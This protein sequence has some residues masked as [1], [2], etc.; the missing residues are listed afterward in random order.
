MAV[1]VAAPAAT[2]DVARLENL[3]LQRIA[4]FKR[5]RYW[6]VVD[7]LPKNS[8]GKVLKRELRRQFANARDGA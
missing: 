2:L 4:R 3:C 7:A 6:R 1:L 5:P 8:V